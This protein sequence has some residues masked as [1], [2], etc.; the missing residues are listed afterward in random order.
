MSSNLSLIT[1]FE[2]F[3]RLKKSAVLS[4]KAVGNLNLCAVGACGSFLQ[5]CRT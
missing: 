2:R 1:G 3:D 5:A 4:W